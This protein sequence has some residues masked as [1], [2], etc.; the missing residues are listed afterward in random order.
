MRLLSAGV[1]RKL[2]CSFWAAA[3][4]FGLAANAQANVSQRLF[5]GESTVSLRLEAPLGDLFGKL[6]NADQYVGGT[7]YVQDETGGETAIPV[8]VKP[9]GKT[10]RDKSICDFPPLKLNF[11]KG[12][13]EGTLFENQDKLKLVTHCKSRRSSYQQYYLQEYLIYKA[14][15]LLTD[16]SF[17]V[18]M[19]QIDYVDTSGRKSVS[20]KYGFFIEDVKLLASRNDYEH[21]KV[22]KSKIKEMDG[23]SASRVSV[24]QY[25][26]SN[27]DWS[28]LGN[29][30]G[31][32]CCHNAKLFLSKENAT[33]PI[34]YDFDHA[35]IIDADYATPPQGV[36][37]R[38]VRV[39]VF[40][41]FCW[42]NDQLEPV[43]DQFK[44][45]KDKIYDIVKKSDLLTDRSKSSMID[46]YKQ[47]YAI[48]EDPDKTERKLY[49][50]CRGAEK[51]SQG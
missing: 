24:F 37:V 36:Q 30:E 35:G 3:L 6:L 42:H 20:G 26:I 46:F 43:L 17:N 45:E 16:A 44:D 34:P 27:L 11:N 50:K 51:E 49:D 38:D 39:R 31:E 25:M 5:E 4:I 23:R 29:V 12:D 1:C 33:I 32:D 14:Y 8:R 28:L 48:I 13:V 19:A 9:R 10:R 7:L 22:K 40:R 41:G 2:K 21:K 15:N 47:F 18:R